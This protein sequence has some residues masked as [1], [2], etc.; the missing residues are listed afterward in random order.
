MK[1]NLTRLVPAIQR[2]LREAEDRRA[3]SAAEAALDREREYSRL[4]VDGANALIVG[5]DAEGHV[6]VFNKT[7][8]SVTGYSRDTL[9]G[10]DWFARV[11]P[12]ERYP[13]AWQAFLDFRTSGGPVDIETPILT[14]AGEERNIAWRYSLLG[15]GSAVLGVM[16]FGID[17]TERKRAERERTALE[18]AARRAEKLAALGTLS[19]GLAHELNNPIG[20]IS[21]R[22]EVMLM[23]ASTTGL[24]DVIRDDLTVLHRNAQRVAQIAKG[25]LSFSRQSPAERAPVRLGDVVR[26]TLLLAGKQLTRD[27]IQLI[28]DLD[29]ALPV[30]VGD[31][32]AL[33]QVV[34]NLLT[35]ARDALPSGGH[36]RIETRRAPDRSHAVRLTVE[37]TGRGVCPDDLARIFDPFF[38]TKPRGTGLGLSISDGIVRE[39][40]GTIDVESEVGRGTRFVLTFPAVTEARG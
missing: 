33:Q 27:G 9:A 8:E 35:N 12:R 25:L 37:D 5:L 36:I 4:L 40:G 11:V 21:S 3:R 24:P 6:T 26:E 18:Q 17:V 10:Q 28:L 19:A 16:A 34:L 1:G 32:N 14:A 15:E 2:E 30:I 39:H 38:S 22:I 20:I 31:T 13:G 23:E 29:D 7:A